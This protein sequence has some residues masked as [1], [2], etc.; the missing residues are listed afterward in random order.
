MNVEYDRVGTL[1]ANTHGNEPIIVL[2]D[3]DGGVF[4]EGVATAIKASD[5]KNPLIVSYENVCNQSRN[6]RH[7]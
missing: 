4:S 1:R 6:H 3:Q 5:D 7:E 2:R